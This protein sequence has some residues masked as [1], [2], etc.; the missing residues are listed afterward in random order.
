MPSQTVQEIVEIVIGFLAEQQGREFEEV[1]EELAARGQEL[2]VD[3]VLLMEILARVEERFGVSVPA[4][5]EAGRSLRSVWAFAET[6]YD[7]MQ[8]KEQQP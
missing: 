2:P 3:S 1:H 8:A 5:A 6:V 4:D 7:T